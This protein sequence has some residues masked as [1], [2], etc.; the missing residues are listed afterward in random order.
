[1]AVSCRATM[2]VRVLVDPPTGDL[3]PIQRLACAVIQ[4]AILDFR[5]DRPT[6]ARSN[7]G[8]ATKMRQRAVNWLS[9]DDHGFR[10]WCDVVGLAPEVVLARV[11]P[12][13]TR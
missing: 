7:A 10:T 13:V 9:R 1:M 11:I 12:S 5:S 8:R 2:L 6:G 4:R 3:T